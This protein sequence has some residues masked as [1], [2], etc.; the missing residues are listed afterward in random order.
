[1][2]MLPRLPVDP[3]LAGEFNRMIDVEYERVRDFL[4]LHY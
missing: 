4:I 1:M 3:R 2:Q